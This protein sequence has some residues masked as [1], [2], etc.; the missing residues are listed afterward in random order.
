MSNGS[1]APDPTADD[2]PQIQFLAFDDLEE[3]VGEPPGFDGVQLNRK[4]FDRESAGTPQL[5]AEIITFKPDFVHHMHRHLNAE[6]V[7]VPLQ[8]SVVMLDEARAERELGAGEAMVVPR[9]RWH[10]V[11]QP[12]RRRLRRPQP[13]LRRRRHV[14]SRFRGLS[15]GVGRAPLRAYGREPSN[16]SAA[17]PPLRRAPSIRPCQAPA[18]CSPAKKSGPIGRCR[19]SSRIGEASERAE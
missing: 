8:G 19:S 12:E 13:V 11:Q 9:Y 10:E 6:Q 16:C 14:G 17:R 15:A 5:I 7:M 1:A 4:V 18:V 2:H 3:V